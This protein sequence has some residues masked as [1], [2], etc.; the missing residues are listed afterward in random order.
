MLTRLFRDRRGNLAVMSAFMMVGLAGVAG[1]VGEYGNGLFNRIMDQ[2]LADTAAVAGATIY[3]ETNSS[4]SMNAAV[5]NVAALNGLSGTV[6]ASIVA[7][8]TGDGNQAIQVTVTSHAPLM[9]SRLLDPMRPAL[10][11]TATSYAEMKPGDT[12]FYARLNA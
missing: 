6:A 12:E 7:S 5:S 1:L 3:D 8:P 2:R 11:I 10:T 4:T 9:L